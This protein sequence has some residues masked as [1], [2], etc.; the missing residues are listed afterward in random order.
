[1][2]LLNIS[3]IFNSLIT[4]FSIP[5]NCNQKYIACLVLLIDI[6]QSE[7]VKSSVFLTRF[8]AIHN[9]HEFFMSINCI[10]H[11]LFVY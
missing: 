6:I 10:E 3:N 7:T 9:V 11:K 1:M 4:K 5:H 8:P 2:S